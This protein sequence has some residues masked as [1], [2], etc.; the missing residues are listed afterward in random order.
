MR[1]FPMSP[2]TALID[3]TPTYNL[4][5]SYGPHLSI[6]DLL[7]TD[8]LAQLRT[9]ELCYG[10]STGD[11]SLRELIGVRHG[12][13]AEQVLVTAGAASAL[14]LVALLRGDDGEIVVVRPSY[15]PMLDAVRGLGANVV[16]VQSRFEDGYRLDLDAVRDALSQRTRLVMVASPQN[17]SGIGIACEEIDEVLAAMQ[18]T[19]P[20]ALLLVDETYR[21]ATAAG[22]S[23]ARSLAALSPQVITCAS[24]SK[25]F[26][27]PGLRIGWLT[28][29]DPKLREQLR[30][31][32][33]NT[34]I[35][36]GT[37]DEFIAERL[38]AR[39][40][41]ILEPRAHH[42]AQ[43]LETVQEW[44]S[45]ESERVRWL[46]P[47]AGAFAAV[48]LR[49][50]KYS[51]DDVNRFHAFLREHGT[52]VAPGIWFGDAP[53][54]IRLGPAYEPAARLTQGLQMI[55]EALRSHEPQ[56]A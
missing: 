12:V 35:C 33:F 29:A 16:T 54:I 18:R 10:T 50:E 23:A 31:A 40:E 44:V 42:L 15:P 37:I 19:C 24:L 5:E 9:R 51:I 28:V 6:D 14:F 34:A 1:E 39:V 11:T 52:A 48:Q 7:D 55:S 22:T 26:G 38:L 47:D 21:E 27:A 32:K 43:A 45:T 41:H 25:A 36:S 20:H 2:I 13:P 3:D 56:R 49:P 17:P 46:R 30:L 8:D 4:A 53:H